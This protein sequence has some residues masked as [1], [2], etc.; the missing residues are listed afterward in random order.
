[1]SKLVQQWVQENPSGPI[2]SSWSRW[3]KLVQ[4]WVQ[5]YPGG[6]I[7]S[8]WSRWFKLVQQWVQASRWLV[9]V[10][11]SISWWYNR[12]Q[13]GS[14]VGLRESKWSNRVQWAKWVQQWVQAYLGGP[15][16]SSW[17]KLVQQWV[18]E[19][20]VSPSVSW[21]SKMVQ[22]WVQGNPSGPIE[23]SESKCIQMAQVRSTVGRGRSNRV[24]VVQSCL[25]D[26]DG[27]SWFSSGSKR[28]QVSPSVSRWHNR[29]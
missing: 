8:S 17:S 4:Q 3:S 20:P 26:P 6:T 13:G 14:A 11:P 1:M 24:Q 19:N 7:V 25:V 12:V 29:V 23:S 9:Q 22:Q 2:V 5:E 27:S 18:Q 16:V 10:G 15:I 21:W 28:I